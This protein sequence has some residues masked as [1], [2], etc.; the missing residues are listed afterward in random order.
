VR[1]LFGSI[2]GSNAVNKPITGRNEHT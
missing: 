1:I 2:F